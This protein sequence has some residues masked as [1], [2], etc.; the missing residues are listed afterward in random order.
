VLVIPEPVVV[1]VFPRAVGASRALPYTVRRTAGGSRVLPFVVTSGNG[2]GGPAIASLDFTG[3]N[4]LT[5]TGLASWVGWVVFIDG[6]TG[7]S[8]PYSTQIDATNKII[9]SHSATNASN[10]AQTTVAQHVAGLLALEPLW[11]FTVV[12]DPNLVPPETPAAFALPLLDGGLASGGQT[13]TE[14]GGLYSGGQTLVIDGG[15]P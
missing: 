15:T 8:L 3:G 14:D 7:P 13:A 1:D 12:G 10:V 6:N 2:P 4:R 11:N 9:Y 5:I